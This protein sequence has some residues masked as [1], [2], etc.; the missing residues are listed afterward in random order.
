M[1]QNVHK[2]LHNIP[3]LTELTTLSLYSQSIYITYMKQICGNPE[4]S[5]FDLGLL[6]DDVKSH[7][8]KII[9]NPCLLLD[10]DATYILEALYGKPWERPEAFYAIHFM[11]PTLPHLSGALHFLKVHWKLGNNLCLNMLLMVRV[12][13]CKALNITLVTFNARKM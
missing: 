6:H 13:K 5:A 10:L 1:E 11:L 9:E 8:K 7:C 4:T 2:A 12:Q 3:T